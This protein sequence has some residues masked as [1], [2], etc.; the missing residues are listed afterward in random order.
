MKKLLKICAAGVLLSSA[1]I[2]VASAGTEQKQS[3]VSPAGLQ[4]MDAMKDVQ[5]ARLALFRGEPD[6]ARNLVIEAKKILEREQDWE[7]AKPLSKK[8]APQAGDF[9]VV[10]DSG[11]TLAEDFTVSTEKQEAI[12]KANKK[13]SQGDKKGAIEDLHLAGVD[14]SETQVLMPLKQTLKKIDCAQELLSKGKYY[15][16]N[17]ALKGAEDGVVVDTET[18]TGD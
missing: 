10:I 12:N 5:F 14:V 11:L 7:S 15:E 8:K 1:M 3:V 18:L 4:G 17:L 9:Y 2:Q 13:L 16:A 6:A